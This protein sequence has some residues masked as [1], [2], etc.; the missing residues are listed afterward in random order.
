VT[1][2]PF[3]GTEEQLVVAVTREGEVYLNDTPMPV[4][5]L[6]KK[7]AAVVR[8]RPDREVY[9]RADKQVSYGRVVEVM[10]AV[11]TAGVKRLGIVTELL[12]EKK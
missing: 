2:A 9:L 1:A 6:G 10:A 5:E 8:L 12:G 3:T 4:D 11:R 7:L